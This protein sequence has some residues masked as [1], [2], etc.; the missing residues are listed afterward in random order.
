MVD[1]TGRFAPY[2][3]YWQLVVWARQLALLLL[4][5][6]SRVA[7]SRMDYEDA[8]PVR[9]ATAAAAVAVL[10]VGWLVHGRH[11]PYALR[12][13]NGLFVAKDSHAGLSTHC[14]TI[15]VRV[16]A[17]AARAG[18]MRQTCCCSSLPSATPH[19]RSA[20]SR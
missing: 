16:P 5:T 7:I 19:S 8:F 11:Q 14:G 3:S 6:L 17:V 20:S 12:R 2:A 4:A 18:S 15:S 9:Y 10:L 1:S 13:Q